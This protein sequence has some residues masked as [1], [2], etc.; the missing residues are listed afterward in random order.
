MQVMIE[1]SSVYGTFPV[2]RRVFIRCNGLCISDYH[3]T[4]QLGVLTQTDA[5]PAVQG[6]LSSEIGKYI[7]GGSL[8][9]DVTPIPVTASNL[10]TGL[11]DRY[12]NELIRLDD[13]E[14]QASDT[15]FTYSDTS[16]YKNT[17]N[18]TIKNCSG[19]SVIVRNSAY[20]N[21]T[22]LPLPKGH[23]DIAA[24]YTIYKSTPTSSSADK[25]LLLRDTSDVHFYG[26]RC[27]SAPSNALLFENFEAYPATSTFPY[28]NVSIP[29]WVNLSE[30]TNFPYSNRTF[31]GNKYAYVSAFGS[32]LTT[33]ATWLVTPAINLDLYT[34]ETFSFDTKQDYRLTNYTG[35]GTDVAST[36]R[37][38]Y[39][40]NYTGTGNPW[41]PGVTWTDFSTIGTVNL[42]LG[43]TTGTSGFPSSYTQSGPINI[44]TLTGTIYIAFKNEGADP[45][46]TT[47][48][49]TSSWEIDNIKIVHN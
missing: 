30:G 2:G 13:Y 32:G 38:M 39:S 5:G 8:N 6:I 9:N 1:A 4:M 3:G 44:S 19:S 41:A 31:S 42:S 28:V 16:A 29:G 27:G 11:Q 21:F 43:T 10:G 26:D 34:G 22:A 45:A 14:F 24:I 35:T 47:S 15:A 12:I 17:V 36:L 33:T 20:A 46:G 18:R 23:G 48:D 49:H 7:V 25:Q 37:V 40:S